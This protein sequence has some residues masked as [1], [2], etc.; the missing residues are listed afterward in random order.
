VLLVGQP[1]LRERLARR[2]GE[3]F[4]QRIGVAYHLGALDL[5][6]T[7]RYLAHRLAVAGR[8]EPI[9]DPGAVGAI[10]RLSGGVPRRINQVAAGALL[11]GF[12]RGVTTLAADVVEAAGADLAA[13]LG[14]ARPAG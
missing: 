5:G 1:E 9:F 12:A 6:E 14:S 11:E 2:G 10:H 13:H 3:A 4:S 8:R 7:D